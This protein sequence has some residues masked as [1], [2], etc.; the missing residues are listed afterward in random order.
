MFRTG[1]G[2]Y[3]PVIASLSFT[4][5]MEHSQHRTCICTIGLTEIPM[6]PLVPPPKP[7][8]SDDTFSHHH[9]QQH[10]PSP[11]KQVRIGNMGT[12]PQELGEL[13]RGDMTI[14]SQPSLHPPI[15][16]PELPAAL[17]SLKGNSAPPPDVSDG[18]LT[19]SML[20]APVIP[21]GGEQKLAH[22]IA[23]KNSGARVSP[24][25]QA[26]W[27]FFFCFSPPHSSH[28]CSLWC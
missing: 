23:R 5:L 11:S 13:G 26:L 19:P 20:E 28:T 8:V 7:F 4:P 3:V 14:D 12:L 27:V 17:K 6:T 21:V 1:A 10:R 9:H 22:I 18:T 15:S 2:T 25:T 16:K 24:S